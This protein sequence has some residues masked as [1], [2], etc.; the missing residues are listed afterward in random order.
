[1]I[2][3]VFGCPIGPG[4]MVYGIGSLFLEM[5]KINVSH[6]LAACDA[7]AHDADEGE[8]ANIS[9]VRSDGR[10]VLARDASADEACC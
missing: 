4:A 5:A 9:A 8:G 2:E 3:E 7:G 1:M 6:M 10:A